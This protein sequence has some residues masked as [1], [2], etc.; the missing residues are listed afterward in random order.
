[1]TPT[2]DQAL[3]GYRDG[4]RVIASSVEL[5]GEPGRLLR[6]VT[7]MAFDGASGTYLTCM[8]LAELHQQAL[9]RTWPAPEAPRPGSVWSHVLLVDFADL[10]ELESLRLLDELF[11]PPTVDK[12]GQPETRSYTG[13][14][15]LPSRPKQVVPDSALSADEREHLLWAAYEGNGLVRVTEP[16]RF[17][18][19]L[20]DLWAQQWPRLR[21]SFGFRTRYRVG[22]KA[23]GFQL[24]IVERL[25]R[26]QE[27]AAPP[28]DTPP[29]LARLSDDLR[30]P[31]PRF[32]KFLQRYGAESERGID[33]LQTLV[34]IALALEQPS[35]PAQVARTICKA[36]SSGREMAGLKRDLFGPQQTVE[37]SVSLTWSAGEA[38]R[39][40]AIMQASPASALDL[41]DL[42]VEARL[43]DLWTNRRK[44]AVSLLV[45]ASS[46]ASGNKKAVRLLVQSGVDHVTGEDISQIGKEEPSLALALIAQRPDLLTTPA[47]WSGGTEVVAGLLGMLTASDTAT[48]DGVLRD[49]LVA[50][51]EDAAREI[52]KRNPGMWWTGL[53]WGSHALR[54]RRS[55]RRTTSIIEGLLN[56]AG[57]ASI[58]NTPFPLD[59]ESMIL[60]ALAAPPQAG[61]WRHA[62]ADQWANVAT[63]L[64]AISDVRLRLRA[65][66]VLLA[67]S[68]AGADERQR[69][70]LWLAGFSAL[71][72]LLADHSDNEDLVILDEV[73]PGAP[74]KDLPTRLREGV[75]REAKR[76]KWAQ[77]DVKAVV[78]AAGPD[79]P[80]LLQA[81]KH[82]AERKKKKS[83]WRE[84]LDQIA[85]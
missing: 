45:D 17:E 40:R 51:D 52:V 49:L 53:Q 31:G 84:V 54:K 65:T 47:S 29:W 14:L 25:Q 38:D 62:G 5:R 23:N 13:P 7:D 61:L 80:L 21:R 8:P 12:E 64:A 60:L 72:G 55:L 30:R 1:V 71:Y 24:Q 69:H 36:F 11:R 34:T 68:A 22:D 48:R 50:R 18:P 44:D 70:D 4:H 3:Y 57:P 77:A 20:L 42:E 74:E 37:S 76:G 9:I 67:A 79:G 63:Q 2:V 56:A 16:S 28:A 85:P 19:V 39:L 35:E 43:S 73:L 15:R 46:F 6:S 32:R 26:N 27:T 82:K 33:D 81:L 83:W 41:V 78:A 59:T 58:G 66:V 75:I 10:G